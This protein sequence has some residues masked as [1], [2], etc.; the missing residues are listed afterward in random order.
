M[1]FFSMKKL[2]FFRKSFDVIKCFTLKNKKMS[3]FNTGQDILGVWNFNSCIL[4]R[5]QINAFAC[6]LVISNTFNINWVFYK[7]RLGVNILIFTII[8]NAEN[9][10]ILWILGNFKNKVILDLALNL[11]TILIFA[12]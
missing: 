3:N 10:W 8:L 7:K 2:I 4:G 9:N 6:N 1:P 11:C 5:K 12:F